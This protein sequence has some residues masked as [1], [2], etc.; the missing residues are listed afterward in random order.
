MASLLPF[1][2]ATRPGCLAVLALALGGCSGLGGDPLSDI[3]NL[4]AKNPLIPNQVAGGDAEDPA[5]RRGTDRE[6]GTDPV[7]AS[8][9][10]ALR[11]ER[12]QQAATLWAN[13]ERTQDPEDAADLYAEIAEEYPEYARA[14]EAR[15]RA[16]VQAY[17]RRAWYESFEQLRSYMQVA[18]VN[19]HLKDIERMVYEGGRRLLAENRE[20]TFSVFKSDEGATTMLTYVAQAF[21]AGLYAD[22]AL[23]VLGR[24]YQG[25]REPDTAA[26][27]YRQLLISYP[28]S[29][30]V[31]M[32]RLALGDTYL[33]RDQ[34]EPYHAGFVDRDPRER[35]PSAE[36]APFAGPVKSGPEL[37][38]EQFEAFLDAVRPDPRR[39]VEYAQH[40]DYAEGRARQI[41]LALAAKERRTAAF[42]RS[43]G[44][45]Q[46]SRVYEEAAQRWLAGRGEAPAVV[47]P[48]GPVVE[49][50]PLPGS[51]ADWPVMP[52]DVPA[53]V[54]A[55]A[56]P[57]R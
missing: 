10:E 31:Y 50:P 15:Y 28:D 21:P 44:D 42:Y 35:L 26:L 48:G 16:G 11:R 32:T 12:M 22:D 55:P 33:E 23:Y 14:A 1:R 9:A 38:L 51:G 41:R 27:T 29:E 25:E 36:A 5:L 49:P 30:W 7:T 46:A 18:P 56:P 34:G 19:P 43:N 39:R 4:G 37:A 40:V 6:A 3:A 17:R 47:V 53:E 52:T 54:P 20:G 13:A 45:G 24:H 8:E 57:G 2:P